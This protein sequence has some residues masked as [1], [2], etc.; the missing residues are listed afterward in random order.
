LEPR[1]VL[2]AG[3]LDEVFREFRDEVQKEQAATNAGQHYKLGLTYFEMG[4]LDEAA[5]TL[6]LAVRSPGYRF[7]TAS[8]LGRIARQRG[9]LHEAIEWFERAAETPAS[10][11]DAGR[12]LLY[13]L[14]QALEDAREWSR[15]LAVYLEL[16]ADAGSYRDVAARVERLSLR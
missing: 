5:R 15:A 4:L 14:G 13:E 16:Q 1:T 11:V 3:S 12:A 10:T 2:P 9:K 6:E 7:Q 8:L